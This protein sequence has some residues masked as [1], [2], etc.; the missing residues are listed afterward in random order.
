MSAVASACGVESAAIDPGERFHRYGLDSLRA[1]RLIAALGERLGR[2]LSPTLAWE[3]PTVDSLISHLLD[4]HT[5]GSGAAHGPEAPAE[6]IAIVGMA[7]RLPQAPD[8]AAFWR[9]L[10][11]G[12]DAVGEVPAERGWD[13][14]L[15]TRGVSPAERTTVRRGAF[16]ARIDGFDP[17]FFGISPRE[18]AAMDPQ[19]RLMLELAWEALEDAG[20][21]P[22]S[23]TGSATGVFA[24][25]IW[26]DYEDLLY[27]A[28]AAALGP[29]TVTGSHY[30]IIANRISYVLGLRGPSMTIDSACSSGLVV[31]HLACES[32]R[33]GE[34]T[35]ALA[36]AV[37]LNVR[38]ESALAVQR[39][40]AL[41]PSGRCHTFDARADGYVRGE[42]GGLVVLKTL[43]RALADGD[44]IRAVIRGSAVNNDGASN[45]LTAPSRAAQEAVLAA[46]YR[47]AGVSAGE[48]QYVEA[49]GTGTPLGDPIE[50]RALGAVLGA[51][52]PTEAPLLV[53]S[54]KTNLGH[55]EGAAGIVGL[56]KTT[57]AIEHREVPPNLHFTA[58]NP[59]APLAEL[60][61]AVPTTAR[62]WPAPERALVAG[63]SSFGLGGTNAH[64]VLQEWP[65]P[66]T[67]A[68]RVE[69]GSTASRV[70]FVFPGQGAQW[71]GMA[72]TLLHEEPVIRASLS[73]CDRLIRRWMDWSLLD[74]LAGARASR[75]EQIECSLP[76]IISLDIAVATWWR[77]RGVEP[78]AVVGHS[79][80]EIAAAHV[81]GILDLADTM[82]T[83][84]AYGRFVGR[85][86]GR[87]GMAFVGLPWDEC[88]R[89]L[90][91]LDARVFRAIEDSVEGTVVAGPPEALAE[92]LVALT[93]RGVFARPVRMDVGPHSPLVDSVREEL[94]AALQGIR[95]R[96]AQVPLISEVT[97]AEV[98]GRTLDA[99]HWVRNFGDPAFF[100]RAI[101]T[102]L[103][104]GHRVFLDVGPHPITAHSLAANL[105][106]AGG[107]SV[108]ASLRRD[109]D[110]RTTLR[111]ASSTLTSL[112]VAVRE[113]ADDAADEGQAWL[114]PL[115][116]RDAG[117][118]AARAGD[119][120][121]LLR[122]GARLRD[123]AFTASARR[124]ALAERL[125]VIGRSR[126][127]LAD[128]L[129]AFAGGQP[130]EGSP[131]GRVRRG[132]PEPRVL[133]F[134]G[135]GSQW[136]GMGRQLLAEEPLF[137]AQVELCD[138]LVREQTG[139]SLLAELHAP[140]ERSR[141]FASEVAQPTLF[142]VQIGLAALLA[143]W[144]VRPDAVIGQ[145]AGEVAAAYV[146]G[147]LTLEDAVR[148]I[149]L[150]GQVLQGASGCGKMAWVALPREAAARAI[151]G[152]EAEVAIAAVNDP[153]SVLLSGGPALAEVLAELTARGVVHRAMPTVD[154]ASHGPLMEPFAASLVRALG[155]VA[156]RPTTVPMYS[157]VVGERI[158]GE[159]LGA[160]YWGRNVREPVELA[161]AVA[162]SFADGH[163]LY[164]EI[165]PH[166]VALQ[167]L[168]QCLAAAGDGRA[169]ATLRRDGDPRRELL[170]TLGEVW[171]HGGEV[172]LAALHPAGGRVLALPA[173]PWQRERHW[174]EAARP[175]RRSADEHP[176]LGAPLAS[177]LHPEEQVWEQGSLAEDQPWVAEH[178]FGD[179][180]IVPGSAFL[181]LSLAAGA[182]IHGADGFA[183][184]ELRFERMLAL[185]CGKLQVGVA[186]DGR[187]TIA[188]RADGTAW[189]RHASG[190]LVAT[191]ADVP[192]DRIGPGSRAG[193][194]DRKAGRAG[195]AGSQAGLS[196]RVAGES[197]VLSDIAT[198]RASDAAV[199]SDMSTGRVG[200]AGSVL[201]DI[202]TGRASEAVLSARVMGSAGDA[203]LADMSTGGAGG[204]V[205]ADRAPGGKIEQIRGRCAGAVGAAEHYATLERWGVAYG[206]RLRSV[207]QVWFGDGEA[208]GRVRVPEAADEAGQA[209]LLD[210]ALQVA[211]ALVLRGAASPAIPVALARTRVPAP[212]PAAAWVHARRDGE[213]TELALLD[214][215]GRVL[216]ELSGLRCAAMAGSIDPLAECAYEVTWR[217]YE[218]APAAREAAEG[219]WIVLGDAGGT[220]AALA[221]AL[222]GR[223]ATCVELAAGRV[224]E[225]PGLL[226]GGCRGVIHCGSLD[227]AQWAETTPASLAADLR[228]GTVS[229]I[230]TARALLAAG[231]R[232]LPRL[233]LVTRGA[234]AIHSD[235]VAAAQA[236]LWGM[237]RTLVLEHPELECLRVDLPPSPA[238][239][240]V[241]LLA[242]TLLADD[243]ET[244][245]ALRAVHD[246][247]AT[248]VKRPLTRFVARLVRSRIDAPAE[249]RGLPAEAT[250]LITGGLGGLG[251][252]LARG[253]ADRGARHL[254]LVGR[255]EPTA[256]ARMAIAAIEATGAKVHVMPGDVAEAGEAARIVGQIA[257]TLP[258]LRGVVHAAAVI[259]D[260][261]VA[262]LEE[263]EFWVPIR[264]K[265]LGAWHLHAATRALPLEF[266]VMYS[267]LV[268]VLGSLGQAAYGAGN[269]FLDALAHARAAEGLP[270]TSVQWGTFSDVGMT[271][272]LLDRGSR[273]VSHGLEHFS[274]AEGN[275]LIE[276]LL[277]RP[278]VEV[279]LARFSLRRWVDST[280][281]VAGA[282]FLSELPQEEEAAAGPSAASG[283][284]REA[285]A[286]APAGE[287]MA[288]LE[289]H[290]VE[291]LGRVLRLP[292]E[293][294][295]RGLPFTRIGLDS[296]MSLETRNRLER[297]L[298]LKLPPTL[299]FTYPDTT[300]LAAFLLATL[301]LA[302]DDDEETAT[303]LDDS[304]DDVLAAFDASLRGLDGEEADG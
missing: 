119:V 132:G 268:A 244:E 29:Y 167:S 299:C 73:A 58:E 59:H 285:V 221:R 247:R 144:G 17:M 233:V 156:A 3:H 158:A 23:L 202:A 280:P 16:L 206:P 88:G 33:R 241:E 24:G 39:F 287:R 256:A 93:A 126:A 169:I 5:E 79:T 286:R 147:A 46:A 94:F 27:R 117:A 130:G 7:C 102:L 210:G 228:R 253:L 141:L 257:A 303:D 20:I 148:V 49:H 178:R 249:V 157:T 205:L 159:E 185:P 32:L 80:G 91:E 214:D 198:G 216:A 84:C 110:G 151:A 106:R 189:T 122:E 218:R 48:V 89:V 116:A 52:R 127:A 298:G 296:L 225:L 123:V 288:A 145:S 170:T 192:G 194:S 239:D 31:T 74:E 51:G 90:A 19:Q 40:G 269:A 72:R 35:V 125:V 82:Q 290:V 254:V 300:S 203:V 105:R 6:P 175:T 136:I 50:A 186:G 57:L 237:A 197:A 96:P 152:R 83:I 297:S 54:V 182:A 36:G 128:E 265:V 155:T 129:A 282:P 11:D 78:S 68:S 193:L 98:D 277:A 207:E 150:R 273:L 213:V 209:A 114:L 215:D 104:R 135:Q 25:A 248:G 245:V 142:T 246:P 204:A 243:D 250:Y 76:A 62:P 109:E 163:R 4:E 229:A 13:D 211:M 12:I 212:L 179:A 143:A 270:A 222:R 134:A 108:I 242:D 67:S 188:S 121:A 161:R 235:A 266:F 199:L 66:V 200:G 92:L 153:G 219:R 149:V 10:H 184:H 281:Q 195:E 284:I 190:R 9:L 18:A 77:S 99:G 86:S 112:G 164:V 177:A 85:F 295:E 65:G 34:S 262:R 238:A 44:R 100:S 267:S 173:Y 234:Q 191:S 63:V 252:A 276:R 231:L 15:A 14:L 162:R 166:P 75:L 168:S 22:R 251:L 283:S 41:S 223:G 154:F 278:R 118:L 60:G 21:A 53:G 47:R 165:G 107:G 26:S 293:K 30:S 230:A 61:L 271:T 227:A 28:G 220:G 187:L 38:P 45:G 113:A 217:R 255:S 181:A 174:V 138:A 140:E 120:A 42:G 226:A 43:A 289:D 2:A 183:V 139:W 240:E 196:D 64:V 71:P 103:E 304:D 301:G 279:A 56:I 176:L 208:L 160:A 97:G 291:Q 1:S 261:T 264:P 180:A 232:D 87:G 274:P 172:D 302:A 259:G 101:D 137:R 133:V 115:S 8:V 258:P 131:R 294:I 124:E 275:A 236:P 111:E 95:P 146:A 70:A 55:L 292:P 201:S 263:A 69:V 37:N 224:D 171:A 81:A 272:A 260:R